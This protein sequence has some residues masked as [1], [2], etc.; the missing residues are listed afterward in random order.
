METPLRLCNICFDGGET[1][2]KVC[3]CPESRICNRC[4]TELNYHSFFTCPLCRR[5]LNTETIVQHHDNM[6][7]MLIH[8]LK[9]LLIILIE[10]VTPIIY[11]SRDSPND[12]IDT[13]QQNIDDT[14]LWVSRD[15]VIIPL[16]SLSVFLVQPLSLIILSY[17]SAVE[18]SQCIKKNE[19]YILIVCFSNLIIEI[20]LFINS[21]KLVAWHYM[22]IILFPL[23]WIVFFSGIFI[24]LIQ[25]ISEYA[26]YLQRRASITRIVPIVVDE[27]ENE[28]D[29]NSDTDSTQTQPHLR[30]ST[31]V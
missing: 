7:I 17:I 19:K 1:F 6:L 5:Q 22:I 23:Y 26:T 13:I 14:A 12:D 21:D 28:P 4:L 29:P 27:P 31:S 30:R 15:N 8:F 2:I 9:V 3:E 25:T 11:F 10:F 24:I 20:V 16:I 18:L